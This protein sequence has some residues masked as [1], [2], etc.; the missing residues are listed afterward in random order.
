MSRFSPINV[1]KLEQILGKLGFVQTR[2]KGSHAF[3]EHSDGRTT[4]VSVHY[5][6]D[7]GR[8]LLKKIVTEDLKM[9][10]EEFDSLR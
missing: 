10:V 3:W 4:L 9:S 7:I 1:R 6:E 5:G 2:Q 8:G